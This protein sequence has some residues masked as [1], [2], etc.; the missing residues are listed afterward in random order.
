M[1]GSE[2]PTYLKVLDNSYRE[3]SLLCARY[4]R[5]VVVRVDL[6]PAASGGLAPAEIN[7]PS[8]RKSI[9]RKLES[10]YKS[11]VAFCW[12][13]EVGRND[14]NDGWHWHWWFAVKCSENM[15]PYTQS[16]RMSWDIIEVWQEKAG[17][18][19]ER[20]NMAGWFYLK[21]DSFSLERRLTEQK[22]IANGSKKDEN[23]VFINRNAMLARK[24]NKGMVLGGVIDEAFYALSYLAKVFSKV[25]T[26][27]SKGK[28]TFASSNLKLSYPTDKKG[29][30][31]EITSNLKDINEWLKEPV[32]PIP[33]SEANL[34]AYQEHIDN[35]AN[36]DERCRECDAAL[37]EIDRLLDKGEIDFEEWSSR[38]DFIRERFKELTLSA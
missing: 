33:F 9:A 20:N 12:T 31:E 34:R 13:R 1:A 2:H 28:P 10:K 18:F 21:R 8:F 5:V 17:G 30:E 35:G 4:S 37:D 19:C 7:I 6:H 24:I 36:Y 25:R 27:A 26:E 32:E 23:D 11:K 3:L 15:Q 16:E 14:Y 22:Q 29:R 38:G